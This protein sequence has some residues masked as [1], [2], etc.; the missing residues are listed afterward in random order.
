M[1]DYVKLTQ[2]ISLTDGGVA[3][4]GM[5]GTIVEVFKNEGVS[6]SQNLLTII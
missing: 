5:I 6:H 3:P 4:V 1:F 2:E